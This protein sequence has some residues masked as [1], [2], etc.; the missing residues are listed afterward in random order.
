MK[1]YFLSGM[2]VNCRVF[3]QIRLPEG[4]EKRYIEWHIPREDETLDEYTRKMAEEIDTSEPFILVGYSLGGIIMQEMN[5]FLRPEKNILIS[6]M[7]RTEEIPR[8]FRVAKEIRFSERFPKSLY[9]V[10]KAI[11]LLFTRL[12]Y[13]MSAEFIERCVTYTSPEYMHWTTHQITHWEPVEPCPNLYH[14]HGTKD[15]VFPSKQIQD[16][17]KIEEGDHV[18]VMKKAEEV[19]RLINEIIISDVS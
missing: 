14:I 3:D 1:V 7:K 9:S 2:C 16:A 10:N 4:Y 12:V 15:Q 18:M 13:D 19:N 11:T 17:Y 6:S 8:L 5:R